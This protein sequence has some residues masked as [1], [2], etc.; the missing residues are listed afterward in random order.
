MP[1]N[2]RQNPLLT[3][4]SNATRR[5]LPAADA[6]A[7]AADVADD[8]VVFGNTMYYTSLQHYEDDVV[9]ACCCLSLPALL[10]MR[11]FYRRRGQTQRRRRQ[12]RMHV[13]IRLDSSFRFGLSL[14]SLLLCSLGGARTLCDGA[15][16]I[17]MRKVQMFA[18]LGPQVSGPVRAAIR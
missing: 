3:A 5:P 15:V 18:R 13:H 9:A 12:L 17:M 1:Q 7:A 8:A 11:V 6:A 4:Q 16:M 2:F 10:H 14:C